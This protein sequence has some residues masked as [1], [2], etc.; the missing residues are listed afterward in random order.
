MCLLNCLKLK[1]NSHWSDEHQCK[2]GK[3]SISIYWDKFWVGYW[4]LKKLGA[5]V[6]EEN[7]KMESVYI[8]IARYSQKN[9]RM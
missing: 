7:K 5:S 8:A 3:C 6:N 4:L 2:W 1:E 9:D